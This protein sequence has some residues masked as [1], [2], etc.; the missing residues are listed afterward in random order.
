MCATGLGSVLGWGQIHFTLMLVLSK[1]TDFP[2]LTAINVAVA[3]S[4]GPDL[5]SIVGSPIG[6][7]MAT[8][9]HSLPSKIGG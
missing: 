6:Q 4:M 2:V 5:G 3:F 7:P 8:V 1:L 9:W